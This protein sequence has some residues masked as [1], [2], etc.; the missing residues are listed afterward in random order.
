MTKITKKP[1]LGS[2]RRDFLGTGCALGA[3]AAAFGSPMMMQTLAR[4]AGPNPD[5]SKD[6]HYIFCYFSGGWD[7]LL[8]LDPR[9]PAQF[10]EGNLSEFRIQP[11]WEYLENPDVSMVEPGNNIQLGPFIGDL[12]TMHWDKLC[13][14]R[15]MS[16]ETL[17]HEVGRRRF[18]TGKPPS[19]LLARGSSVATYLAAGLGQ[20]QPVPNLAVSV[21]SYNVDLPTYASGFSVLGV[22][23]LVTALSGPSVGLDPLQDAQ[24]D[25]VMSQFANCNSFQA[26]PVLRA[27]EEGR[28]KAREMVQGGFD[29]LFNFKA[30]SP[31]MLALRDHYGFNTGNSST[32]GVLSPA[33]QA[34]LAVTA[35]TSGLSRVVSIQVA[36]GLDTH[37]D[38]WTDVQGPRQ[39]TG[40]N[41]IARMVEDLASRPYGPGGE[42]WLDHTTIVGFSE[43]SRTSMLNQNTGRDHSLTNACLMLG[44]GIKPG[45]IGASSNVGMS[46]TGTDLLTGMPSQGGEIV[47]P[48]HVLRALMED[49]GITDDIADLRVDPLRAALMNG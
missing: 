22:N 1:T 29:S 14:V 28:R 45:I 31:E 41:A 19:G 33:G 4:A 26:S 24:L 39:Q 47:K 8:G 3:G 20:Q 42:S 6:R 11:G 32:T 40:F 36:S 21:E 16:A 2:S 17:T 13:V 37:Y 25:A 9:H 27:A 35:I 49:I 30:N 7:I 43:F 38:D 10:N 15:G 18:I 23:D 12:G 44:A 34:A 5:L 48:E 46:P